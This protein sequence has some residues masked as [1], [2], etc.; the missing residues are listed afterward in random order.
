VTN[1]VPLRLENPPDSTPEARNRHKTDTTPPQTSHEN[2]GQ[3]AVCRSRKK[4]TSGYDQENPGSGPLMLI[5]ELFID[6][7]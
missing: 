2:A 1:R 5:Q 6:N 7:N 4:Q 3:T